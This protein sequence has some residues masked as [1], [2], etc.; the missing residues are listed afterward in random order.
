MVYR[1]GTSLGEAFRFFF[2]TDKS[3]KKHLQDFDDS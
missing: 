2:T 1:V 3:L